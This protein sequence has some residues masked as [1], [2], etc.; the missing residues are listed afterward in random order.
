MHV[1]QSYMP[2]MDTLYLCLQRL[3]LQV[4]T[5]IKRKFN[6]PSVIWY[7]ASPAQPVIAIFIP[8]ALKTAIGDQGFSVLDTLQT[9]G[10]D[11]A[12]QNTNGQTGK[13]G[14]K[15]VKR[16][17]PPQ[18]LTPCPMPC[19]LLCSALMQYNTRWPKLMRGLWWDL[20]ALT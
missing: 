18:H 1:Y 14:E 11:R 20:S 10:M 2:K 17:K 3:I 9:Q 16:E 12:S 4:I 6:T 19:A 8:Q 13:R 7:H 15:E 5:Y